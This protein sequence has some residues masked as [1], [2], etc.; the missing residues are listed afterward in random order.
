MFVQRTVFF[1]TVALTALALTTLIVW[2]LAPGGWTPAKAGILASFACLSPW[3]GVCL[4][5]ALPGFAVLLCTRHPARA[6][7]P[8]SGD[9]E[10]APITLRTALAVTIRDEDLATV[11][12]PQLR[13]LD[14]LAGHG[15]RFT[16]FVLSDAQD[17]TRALA[18]A[19]EM[20]ALRAASADPS[21]IRYRR[22][23]VNTGFKA[24]NLMDF[25]DHDADGFDLTVTLDADSAMSPTAVLR[26]VRI[27]QTNP[28]I[29]IVQHLIVGRPAVPA[30]GRLFQ[31]GMRAGM[32][33]W[34]TGQAWWQGD[35]GPYWG[36]NAIVR[37]APFREHGRLPPL[38][39]GGAILSH[40]Q[41]EAVRLRAAGW[42]VCVWAEEEGS[43]ESTPP[44]LPEF[45]ARDSRW[46]AGNLQYCRLLRLRGL[47]V[48]GRWQLVQAILMFASAPLYTVMLALAAISAATDDGQAFPRGHMLAL[49]TAWCAVQY[50]PK[51]LGYLEVMLSPLHR[52]AYGG[53]AAI[54]IGAALEFI[55]TLLLDAVS[56]LSRTGA[57]LRLA[58]RPRHGWP[59]QNREARRV[60]WAEAA[61]LFW[62]HTL[63][64]VAVFAALLS[65]S[66][67]AALWAFPFAGGLVLAIPFCM[68]SAHPGLGR[69]LR[70]HRIAAVPEELRE[71]RRPAQAG[72][73]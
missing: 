73:S 50:A 42:G 17:C 14:G 13:L 31:F 56:Q 27:M 26:L 68:L 6:V 25:L 37:I 8:V 63:F 10:F 7:L 35:E 28:R 54:A 59:P 64:G 70:R 47:R 45:L 5:N 40:D 4:G 18:E 29:G 16:L 43:Q 3:L 65:S 53:A 20:A 69:W 24:G 39:G 32:R 2:A 72:F 46:L 1:I 49:T 52:A 57:M 30:F 15:E 55:F 38:P 58:L 60:S 51:L 23:A 11:L 34:A 9:I 22:R 41:I 19:S 67:L 48:L 66:W 61:R 62:P 21:R 71:A 12:P 44:A 36:H 33:V